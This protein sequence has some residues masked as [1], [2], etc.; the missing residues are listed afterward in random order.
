MR[1]FNPVSANWILTVA[2]QPGTIRAPRKWSPLPVASASAAP[3]VATGSALPVRP[4]AIVPMIVGLVEAPVPAVRPRA[5]PVVGTPPC[6]LASVRRMPSAASTPGTRCVSMRSPHS[7]V[8]IAPAAA[9]VMACV[10]TTRIASSAPATAVPVAGRDAVRPMQPP[11]V[12]MRRW[13]PASVTRMPSAARWSGTASVLM[14]W[15]PWGAVHAGAVARSAGMANVKAVNPARSA[16]GI[17]GPAPARARAVKCTR[18]QAATTPRYRNVSVTQTSS[19]VI[20]NG[21][22][23]AWPTSRPSIAVNVV[24]VSP[25]AMARA[26]VATAAVARAAPAQQDNFARRINA[27]MLAA[28][29]QNAMA[30]SAARTDAGVPAANASRASNAIPDNANRK[31]ASLTVPGRR[32]AMTAAAAVVASALTGSSASKDTARRPVLPVA[33]GSSAAMTGAGGAAAIAPLIPSATAMVIAPL[34]A[35]PIV[36]ASSAVMMAA[37]G[38][39]GAAHPIS[40]VTRDTALPSARQIASANSAATMAAAAPAVSVPVARL[41]T[42]RGT[43]FLDARPIVP[44]S[45]VAPMGAVALVEI[46]ALA[47]PAMPL[48][49]ARKCASP[50]A[51]ARSAAMTD[52]GD[53]AGSAGS[54]RS[55][56]TLTCASSVPP[57]APT[58]S[59]ATMAAAAAAPTA[60]NPSRVAMNSPACWEAVSKRMSGPRRMPSTTMTTPAPPEKSSS[61]ASAFPCRTRTMVTSRE[62]AAPRPLLVPP[63]GSSLSSLLC[64]SLPEAE[65]PGTPAEK[66]LEGSQIPASRR[67][68]LPPP[69]RPSRNSHPSPH[70]HSAPLASTICG[71]PVGLSISLLFG[72]GRLRP[73][74]TGGAGRIVWCLVGHPAVDR[75]LLQHP[76]PLALPGRGRSRAVDTPCPDSKNVANALP[77]DAAEPWFRSGRPANVYI[78][79]CHADDPLFLGVRQ[80][81]ALGDWWCPPSAVVSSGVL[82]ASTA[83]CLLGP[84]TGPAQ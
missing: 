43:A 50:T 39:V 19:V 38:S 83:H 34:P 32:A 42:T 6:K 84:A 57:I 10:T 14:K 69:R 45:S 8:V 76:L 58:S 62:G 26:A 80:K 49:N 20:P 21:T 24:P 37:A 15:S 70:A 48:A 28:A 44:V 29:S 47:R 11:L 16:P 4:V 33:P 53:P 66:V 81:S 67:R 60:R 54:A 40:S 12:M 22:T 55:A 41:A 25:I 3:T 74:G 31:S 73:M 35:R 56:T 52:A 61:L 78:G 17:A 79:K 77:I 59:A 75:P 51:W 9:V 63:G 36:P 7:T 71:G 2:R 64:G 30:W 1:P 18:T 46:A 82:A 72:A 13:P 5:G 23:N 68:V 65:E 27:R